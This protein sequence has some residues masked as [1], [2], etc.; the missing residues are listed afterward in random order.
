MSEL[1]CP[2]CGK[3]GCLDIDL[4]AYI[5]C[6][7]DENGDVTLEDYSEDRDQQIRESM[8]DSVEDEKVEA[9]CHNCGN[10]SEVTEIGYNEASQEMQIK[11]L[12]K[13]G[14]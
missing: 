9:Y 8:S 11:G 5:P 14:E 13:L 12:K 3:S 2:Y 6:N 4:K 1:K 7:I 10:L